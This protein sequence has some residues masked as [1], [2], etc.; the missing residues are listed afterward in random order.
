MY[1]IILVAL[2]LVS[3]CATASPGGDEAIDYEPI[4]QEE[5]AIAG[6]RDAEQAVRRLRPGWELRQP[7]QSGIVVIKEGAQSWTCY[8][9]EPT[10]LYVDGKKWGGRPSS[11]SSL[12]GFSMERIKEIRYIRRNEPRPDGETR[13][14][15]LPAIH[16]ITTSGAS[17]PRPFF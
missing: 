3:G 10:V 1:A 15:R 11:L 14:P 7:Y 17:G 5:L 2:F 16:V 4:G 13:C 8:T 9:D 12:S 6:A